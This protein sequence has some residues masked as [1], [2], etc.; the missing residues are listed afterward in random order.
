[1]ALSISRR[2]TSICGIPVTGNSRNQAFR[3][4]VGCAVG[5]GKPGEVQ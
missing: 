2:T 5:G 1:M 4:L 3:V